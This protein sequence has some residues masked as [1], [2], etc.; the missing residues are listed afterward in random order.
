[1]QREAAEQIGVDQTTLFNWETGRASPNLRAIPGVVRFLGYDPT[2]TGG[3]LVEQL[4]AARLR[5]GWS[6]ADLARHLRVDPCTV[7]TWE[8]R[9]SI[10]W[11]RY[12]EQVIRFLASKG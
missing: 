8:V 4:Q 10:P 3:S 7:S 5:R 9:G 2:R 11:L 6:Q 1:M 12:Q